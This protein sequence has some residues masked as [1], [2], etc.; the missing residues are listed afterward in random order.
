[1]KRAPCLVGCVLAVVLARAACGHGVIVVGTGPG[2]SPTVRVFDAQTRTLQATF[3]AFDSLYTGGVSIAVGN[4]LADGYSYVVAGTGPGAPAMITVQRPRG[5]LVYKLSVFP[6]DYRGGV[7]VAVGDVSGD[8][9]DDIIVGMNESPGM[10]AVFDGRSRALIASF[11]PY[12]DSN[13][14][15]RVTA[16]RLTPG[17]PANIIVARTKTGSYIQ[18]FSI[19]NLRTPVRAIFAN[20]PGE[21]LNIAAGSFEGA[22]NLDDIAVAANSGGD[23]IVRIY[24]PDGILLSHFPVAPTGDAGSLHLG[25]INSGSAYAYLAV[26]P[27]PRGPPEVSVF[28]PLRGSLVARF[29][30]FT[31]SFT[32]GLSVA[33][34]DLL[35]GPSIRVDNGVSPVNPDA[36]IGEQNP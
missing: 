1:M 33:G 17:Q 14:G 12:P 8:G 34:D 23:R 28:D 24:R 21:G 20:I 10:V 11:I 9:A 3:P 7:N 5:G 15:V 27:G 25:V 26:A 36:R 18:A 13:Q 29:L 4:L 30:A 19:R 32:G 6:G 22:G 2:V 16:G 35:S 31:P